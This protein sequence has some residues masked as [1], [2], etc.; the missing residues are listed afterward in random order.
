[1]L[2]SNALVELYHELM[3]NRK[4]SGPDGVAIQQDFIDYQNRVVKTVHRLEVR[5]FLANNRIQGLSR[6]LDQ[7]MNGKYDDGLGMAPFDSDPALDLKSA[8]ETGSYLNLIH[9]MGKEIQKQK[10]RANDS[11]ALVEQLRKEIE[12][13]QN[14]D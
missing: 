10:D 7:C 5:L 13:L 14:E 1:M 11:E 6:I 4:G 3:H 8:D 9:A 12:E 2:T